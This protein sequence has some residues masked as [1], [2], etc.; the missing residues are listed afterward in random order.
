MYRIIKD[1]S[2]LG[3]LGLIAGA[4][5][6]SACGDNT[7][8]NNASNNAEN[9]LAAGPDAGNLLDASGKDADG[10]PDADSLLNCDLNGFELPDDLK[11]IEE[12]TYDDWAIYAYSGAELFELSIA[13][14][15]S[16]AGIGTYAFTNTPPFSGDATLRLGVGCTDEECA[17]YYNAVAGTLD[18]MAFEK[19]EG[20]VFDATLTNV[21]FVELD[22]NDVPVFGGQT[23]C[24]N[25]LRVNATVVPEAEFTP[26]TCD[27]DG[28]T[29]ASNTS[30]A[31]L[32]FGLL[33]V[34]AAT[35][36][37]YPRDELLMELSDMAG[38]ATSVGTYELTEYD[39]ASCANCL[40]I[41]RY[42]AN[43][44]LTATYSAGAGTLDITNFG[45]VGER[46]T[47]TLSGVELVEVEI[48]DEIL[49]TTI[50]PNGAGYCIDSLS[51][52]LVIEA[53]TGEQL[54]SSANTP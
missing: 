6:L 7:A 32:D 54:T 10:A 20:G 27:T 47:A 17:T 26:P 13:R 51:F 46:F 29:P 4:V 33:E 36:T 48:D 41:H 5:L 53:P 39:Y 28:F 50:V 21:Q 37:T 11:I 38:G 23:W 14:E 2:R 40:L 19:N 8:F 44:E 35:S 15:S 18:V 16:I 52:D 1:M 22:A 45:A 12:S 9:N 43:G 24:I 30:T 3:T 31:I 34:T 49:E 42:D 25:A